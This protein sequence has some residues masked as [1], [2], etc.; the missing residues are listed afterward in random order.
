M[1]V[2]LR[3]YGLRLL[4]LTLASYG[5]LYHA[6]KY[7]TPDFGG[8][9]FYVYQEMYEA[10][11]DHE[12]GSPFAYRMRARSGRTRCTSWARSTRRTSRLRRPA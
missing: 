2:T 5:L 3:E 1:H 8:N 11:F 4:V 10:P 6:Y 9:D 7:Y 12:A